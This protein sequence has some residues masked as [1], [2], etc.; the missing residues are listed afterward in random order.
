MTDITGDKMEPLLNNDKEAGLPNDDFD[1]EKQIE[2]QM[3]KGFISKVYSLLLVQIAVTGFFIYLSMISDFYVKT[4]LSSVFLFWLCVIV[5]FTIVLLPICSPDIYRKVPINYILLFVFTI[6][7][8]HIVAICTA[9]VAGPTVV[10][11]IIAT[12]IT[13]LSLTIYAWKTEDDFTMCGGS[14]SVALTNLI[15]LS[16]IN[17]FIGIPFLRIIE[18]IASLIIFSLYL[19]YDTQLIVGQKRRRIENDDYILAV[20]MLYLDIINIFLDI[21]RLLSRD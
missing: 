6:C 9:S 7:M 3:R 17:I 16:I 13:V 2:T 20:M 21:L 5:S 19:I 1:I 10:M 4:F 11:A 18:I 12:F 15:I 8:S 14:L